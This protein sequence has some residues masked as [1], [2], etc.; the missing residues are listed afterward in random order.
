[1]TT[2]TAAAAV[3]RRWLPSSLRR[4]TTLTAALRGGSP[5]CCCGPI[6][7][8]L[9]ARPPSPLPGL[10]PPSAGRPP[11]VRR[12]LSGAAIL[13]KHQN[14]PP[15]PKPPPESEI[16]ESFL[17]GS[18]PGGQKINKTNSAVQLKHVPTGTV[19]K[20]QATRS[21]SQN[22]TIARRL[23]ADRLD[24]LARGGESRSAV[25]GEVRR[26]KKASS[27]KKSRRKY[28]RLAEEGREEGE[29]E[30]EEVEGGGRREERRVEGEER[31]GIL[32]VETTKMQ[33]ARKGRAEER[34]KGVTVD[35]CDG[36]KEEEQSR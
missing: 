17:K 20:C 27:A 19:V 26:R 29:G 21:R 4:L 24:D 8:A 9:P 30:E 28:R 5:C 18:G 34:Q 2:A 25:V 36:I 10:P 22:R 15:R 1:M 14:F 33:G 13:R 35:T 31:R 6:R 12:S 16:E 11:P 23:L 3:T 7:E 32:V